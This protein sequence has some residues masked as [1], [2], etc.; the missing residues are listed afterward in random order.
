MHGIEPPS[1][2]RLELTESEASK[3]LAERSLIMRGLQLAG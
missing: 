3:V 2:G 1:L